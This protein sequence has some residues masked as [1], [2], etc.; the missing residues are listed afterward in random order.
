MRHLILF[1]MIFGIKLSAQEIVVLDALTQLPIERVSVTTRS[2]KAGVISNKDGML[3]LSGFNPTDTLIIR[4]LAYQE[5][6]QTKGSI[7]KQKI[8]L[9]LKPHSLQHIKITEPR[10]VAL[11]STLNHLKITTTAILNTQSAQASDLLKK[12]IGISVQN[13]QNGGGSPNLRGMEANRLLIIVDGIP[14][15]NTIFRGG[16]LQSA[17]I[18]NP[19]FLQGAEVLF[20]PA[21]VAYGNGA[22]GGAILFNTKDPENENNNQFIQQYESSSNAIFISL[23]SNYTLKN[24]ANVS[25]FSIKSY[26]DLRMEEIGCMA[27]KIG[28]K[29]L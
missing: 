11:K 16:H 22:M 25:G 17:S 3:N 5:I 8:L 19:T 10:V 27:L 2:Q 6:F 14:L 28:E 29:N 24:S 1:L 26:G 23:I 21:S 9:F 4:H 20:G 13:S 7:Q 15:N 18:I 12:A